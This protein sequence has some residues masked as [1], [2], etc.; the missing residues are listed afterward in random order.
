MAHSALEV[1]LNDMR[2]INSRFTYLLTLHSKAS[3]KSKSW[4]SKVQLYAYL[5]VRK[6][7]RVLSTQM[8]RETLDCPNLDISPDQ[9]GM[10]TSIWQGRPKATW[11]QTVEKDLAPHNFGLYTAWRSAQN[12]VLWSRI[13]NTGPCSVGMLASVEEKVGVERQAT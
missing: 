10:E 1:F 6:Q 2:Y 7:R 13:M 11:L 4:L 3:L 12:H 8:F 5:S 9:T